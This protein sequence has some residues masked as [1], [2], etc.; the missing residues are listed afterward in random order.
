MHALLP[1]LDSVRIS[2]EDDTAQDAR[3]EYMQTAG[4]IRGLLDCVL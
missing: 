4:S 2:E 3:R 1:N